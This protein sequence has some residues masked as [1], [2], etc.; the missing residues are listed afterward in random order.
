MMIA[1]SIFL[2]IFLNICLAC[3]GGKKFI[4]IFFTI[5]NFL[6]KIV[7]KDGIIFCELFEYL[8]VDIMEWE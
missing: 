2:S 3:L 1:S 8:M 5:T 4:I 7:I 6:Q